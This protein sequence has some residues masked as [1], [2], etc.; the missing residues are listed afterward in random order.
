[1]F[2]KMNEETECLNPTTPNKATKFF[3]Y[4]SVDTS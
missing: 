2:F 4:S 1:M 3:P